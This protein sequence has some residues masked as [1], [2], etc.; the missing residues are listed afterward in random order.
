MTATENSVLLETRAS[1]SSHRTGL[2]RYSI[3]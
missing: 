3:V 1:W 2:L